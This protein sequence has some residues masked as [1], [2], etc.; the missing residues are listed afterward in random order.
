MIELE[1]GDVPQVIENNGEEWTAKWVDH[2]QNGSAISKADK[3]RYSHPQIKDAIRNETHDKCAYCESKVTQVYPG[4]VEHIL[5]KKKCPDLFVA[6]DNLTFC[7]SICNNKKRDYYDPAEPFLNP[8]QD[9]PED[10][11]AFHGPMLFHR[12]G[13]EKGERTAKLLELS[14]TALV[15]RRAE[16]IER[17][18]PLIDRWA[19]QEEGALKE[20]LLREI[21]QVAGNQAEYS[22]ALRSFLEQHVGI[23]C[24]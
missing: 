24:N 11:L 13:S 22:A 3:T 2:V 7:C 19:E 9:N 16:C 1:K 17:I 10:H 21:K 4:D 15:E 6:W 8:Y 18:K 12:P 5:P 20:L 14:R 23:V